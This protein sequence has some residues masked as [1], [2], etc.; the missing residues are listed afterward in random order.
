MDLGY[1][2]S[3][4]VNVEALWEGDLSRIPSFEK[5]QTQF[6]RTPLMYMVQK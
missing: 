6:D 2:P 5:P 4:V 3:Q 1:S